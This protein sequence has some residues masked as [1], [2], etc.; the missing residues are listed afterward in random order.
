MQL[1]EDKLLSPYR[2]KNYNNAKYGIVCSTV[3]NLFS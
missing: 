2:K 3:V 1:S